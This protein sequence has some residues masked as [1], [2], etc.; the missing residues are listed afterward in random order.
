MGQNNGMMMIG[1]LMGGLEK[2]VQKV[3]G[4]ADEEWKFATKKEERSRRE[5]Q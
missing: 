2:K 3:R 5:M 4:I 1:W